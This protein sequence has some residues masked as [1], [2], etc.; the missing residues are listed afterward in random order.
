[1]ESIDLA[2]GHDKAEVA[3]EM[4]EEYYPTLHIESDEQIDFPHEG[5]ITFHYKKVSSS[6][7]ERDGKMHYS[8]TLEMHEIL[9]MEANTEEDTRSESKKTEDVLDSHMAEMEKQSRKSKGY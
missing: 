4:P 2:M 5:E 8:C 6:M 1:M 9:D 3:P 7:N